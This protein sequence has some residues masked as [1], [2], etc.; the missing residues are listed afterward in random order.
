MERKCVTLGVD[1]WA[2][3]PVRDPRRGCEKV[4]GVGDD[5][6]WIKRVCGI[7]FEME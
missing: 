1:G 5:M 6:L 3:R 7:G 2:E 4:W